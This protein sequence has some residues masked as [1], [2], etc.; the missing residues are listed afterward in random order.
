[1][2]NPTRRSLLKGPRAERH[3]KRQI[4]RVINVLDVLGCCQQIWGNTTPCATPRFVF[5]TYIAQVAEPLTHLLSGRQ[6]H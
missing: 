4:A 5:A 1:M 6:G 2:H 3:Q